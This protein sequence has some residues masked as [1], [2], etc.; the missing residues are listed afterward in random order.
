MDVRLTDLAESFIGAQDRYA[1]ARLEFALHHPREAAPPLLARLSEPLEP[2]LRAQWPRIEI[3]LQEAFAFSGRI[4][5]TKPRKRSRD[6]RY[7]RLQRAVRELDQ[8]AR[9]IRWALVVTES[10]EYDL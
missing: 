4:E 5:R 1:L 3:Q 6:A 9:A 7:R 10:P 2:A 8:Y